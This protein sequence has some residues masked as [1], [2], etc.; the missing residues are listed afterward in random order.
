MRRQRFK[1]MIA[2]LRSTSTL[3][4]SSKTVNPGVG[5]QLDKPVGT[6]NLNQIRYN[7]LRD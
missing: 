6:H 7:S 5:M 4:T 1:Q 3:H 2:S